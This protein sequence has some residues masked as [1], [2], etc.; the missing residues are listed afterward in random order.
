MTLSGFCSKHLAALIHVVISMKLMEVPPA[1][2]E[3]TIL[4]DSRNQISHVIV[5]LDFD[6]LNFLPFIPSSFNTMERNQ[7][8]E[9]TY[10]IC[11]LCP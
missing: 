5:Y 2:S 6:F 7:Q 8:I 9:V 11:H 10:S 4:I 1:K 3:T